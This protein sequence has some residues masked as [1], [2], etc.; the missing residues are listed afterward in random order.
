M[1][2]LSPKD[3]CVQCRLEKMNGEAKLSR[4]IWGNADK[5][6]VGSVVKIEE[7][8]GSWTAD[9]VVKAVYGLPMPK[10]AVQHRSHDHTRQRKSSDI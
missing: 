10:K 5:A 4:T 3:M 7:D 8:D 9:W 2:S 1:A 6:L